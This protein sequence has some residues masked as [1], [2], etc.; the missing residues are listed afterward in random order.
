VLAFLHSNFAFY[1]IL[2]IYSWHIICIY[3]FC[4]HSDVLLKGFF[5]LRVSAVYTWWKFGNSLARLPGKRD[6]ICSEYLIV[7]VESNRWVSGRVYVYP[8]KHLSLVA[9]YSL[10]SQMTAV[11][12]GAQAF[13]IRCSCRDWQ[14]Q[15][16]L[17]VP[18][19][20]CEHS[21]PYLLNVLF[22]WSLLRS[23]QTGRLSV[24]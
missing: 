7:L 6:G 9:L 24:L 12:L 23:S 4:L 11:N 8:S 20:E 3:N 2:F 22:D 21:V 14:R 10:S 5:T 18:G 19:W 1:F 17:H 13:R 15:C 16:Y